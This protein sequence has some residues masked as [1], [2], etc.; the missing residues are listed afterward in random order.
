MA[1]TTTTKLTRPDL[2]AALRETFGKLAPPSAALPLDLAAVLFATA[3]WESGG[4]LN[5]EGDNGDSLGLFQVNQPTWADS[6]GAFDRDQATP[7]ALQ[8][9]EPGEGQTLGGAI[10]YELDYVKPVVADTLKSLSHALSALAARWEAGETVLFNPAA[11]L[12]VWWS[13]AWQYGDGALSQ[14][15]ADPGAVDFTSDGFKAHRVSSGLTIQPDHDARQ[16]F[17][18]ETYLSSIQDTG[19]LIAALRDASKT[20]GV[21]LL[22]ESMKTLGAAKDAVKTWTEGAAKGLRDALLPDPRKWAAVGGVS[23]G[24]ALAGGYLL[25]HL[26][27]EDGPKGRRV[28]PKISQS[29]V[30]WGVK[31]LATSE[32]V[33]IVL[34]LL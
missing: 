31:A 30:E 7:G 29:L 33:S 21:D 24:L 14:W 4:T 13:V 8:G 27:T 16:K 18:T 5:R 9:S 3:L 2:L 28:H 32:I 34:G 26:V 17:F 11:D 1:S 6:I 12:P 25:F 23:L 19:V 10:A 15:V 20:F 22:T